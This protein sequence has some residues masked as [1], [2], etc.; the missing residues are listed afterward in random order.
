MYSVVWSDAG[1][2]RSSETEFAPLCLR[3]GTPYER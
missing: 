3:F 1:S 2:L